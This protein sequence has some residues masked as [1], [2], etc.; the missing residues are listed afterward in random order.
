M[1]YRWP[2]ARLA[3][4]PGQSLIAS[5]Q[6]GGEATARPRLVPL[7]TIHKVFYHRTYRA[8][9]PP[10]TAPA[11]SDPTTTVRET[12]DLMSA[13]LSKALEAVSHDFRSDTVTGSPTRRG[14]V[15]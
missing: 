14:N 8:M 2:S 9:P 6:P 7:P 11:T 10:S 3:S 15:C 12:T 13:N 5:D 1:H 4:P